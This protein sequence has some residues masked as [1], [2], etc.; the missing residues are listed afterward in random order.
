MFHAL[1]DFSQKIP[2]IMSILFV[3]SDDYYC[4]RL[5]K[6]LNLPCIKVFLLTFTIHLHNKQNTTT[7]N[8]ILIR[9][10]NIIYKVKTRPKYFIIFSYI[11]IY[12]I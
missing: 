9:G 11:Y 8:I 6:S 4:F 10:I 5:F 3:F 7:I 12:V 1:I 2:L